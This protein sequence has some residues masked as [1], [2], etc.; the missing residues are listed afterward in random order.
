MDSRP[1]SCGTGEI[2]LFMCERNSFARLPHLLAHYRDL[3]VDRFFVVDNGSSDGSRDLLLAQ[4]DVHLFHTEESYAE[5]NCGHQ[6]LLNLIEKY[7]RDRWCVA[8]DSDEFLTYPYY[9]TVSL[10]GLCRD[11][12]RE[13][14]SVMHCILFDMYADTPIRDVQYR[15]DT[16]PLE[17]CNFFEAE[18]IEAWGTAKH[19]GGVRGRVFSIRPALDKCNLFKATQGTMLGQGFHAQRGGVVSTIHGAVLHFKFFSDFFEQA[20]TESVRE[21]HWNHVS[22]YK[23]YHDLLQRDPALNLWNSRSIP[24]TGSRQLLELGVLVTSN[25]RPGSIER[26]GDSHAAALRVAGPNSVA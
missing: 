18:S 10:R 5:A 9:E 6:W 2:R 16:H 19:W 3:G 7:G 17:V 13:G 11:M 14:S 20:R 24:F 21:E 8:A 15:A 26:R 22:E 12:E 4:P 23:A 1:I 25:C